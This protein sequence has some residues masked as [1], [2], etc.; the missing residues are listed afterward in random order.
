MLNLARNGI[1]NFGID[2]L[3]EALIENEASALKELDIS[4]NAIGHKGVENLA[5]YLGDKRCDLNKLNVSECDINGKG[6]LHL[7]TGLK[8]CATLHEIKA[9]KSDFGARYVRRVVN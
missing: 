6:A 2:F 4:Q 1:T 9:Y 5:G 3:R 7:L 8:K